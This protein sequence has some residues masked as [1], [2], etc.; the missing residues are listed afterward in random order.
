[1]AE[2]W[3]APSL[4]AL[5]NSINREFPNRD[6]SS[7]GWIGDAS[8][9]ARKSE[10]NPCWTCTGK[11]YGVVRATDTDIDDNDAGRDLR[12]ELLAATIGHPAV[13]YV[14]SNGVIYSRT[15]GWRARTYTG[16]NAHTKHVHV[17][18]RGT[19]AAVFD[20]SL[21]LKALVAKPPSGGTGVPPSGGTNRFDIHPSRI[22][23]MANGFKPAPGDPAV[24]EVEALLDWFEDLTVAGGPPI[25]YRGGL[26]QWQRAIRQENYVGAGRLLK[27]AIV[28]YQKR[29]KLVPDGI[30]GPK[31]AA[32]AGGKTGRFDIIGR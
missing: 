5:R 20:L 7:D 26:A 31:S 32:I 10:H 21:K 23:N 19:E 18:I 15:Y 9:S 8:H 16:P 29:Y 11:L 22:R 14:I 30:F 2:Y 28:N 27:A 24:K 6:K 3:L 4:V 17:S 25:L 12:R 1:M 13:W